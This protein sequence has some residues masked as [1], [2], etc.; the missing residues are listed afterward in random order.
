MTTNPIVTGARFLLASSNRSTPQIAAA[1][2]SA[3]DNSVPPPTHILLTEYE[4]NEA[5]LERQWTHKWIMFYVS[6]QLTE[7]VMCERCGEREDNIRAFF[8]DKEMGKDEQRLC[9]SCYEEMTAVKSDWSFSEWY[10]YTQEEQWSVNSKLTGELKEGY[11]AYCKG[12][13]VVPYWNDRVLQEEKD[14]QDGCLTDTGG[15]LFLNSIPK[16]LIDQTKKETL[17]VS[18]KLRLIPFFGF[19]ND[20]Y[21]LFHCIYFL[22]EIEGIAMSFESVFLD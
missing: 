22:L 2:I 1:E 3:H 18:Y 6:D 20:L 19:V 8:S 21:Y 5:H 13:G 17:L 15:F 10:M 12:E 16:L 9:W 4:V 7:S 14:E 11:E